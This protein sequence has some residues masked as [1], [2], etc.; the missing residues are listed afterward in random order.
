MC[1]MLGEPRTLASRN[2]IRYECSHFAR[3]H[4]GNRA[5]IAM[6]N[7]TGE[8]TE[9]LGMLELTASGRLLMTPPPEEL[10]LAIH[11][12]DGDGA[13]VVVPTESAP[14]PARDY[15]PEEISAVGWKC[16]MQASDT[17]RLRAVLQQL[18]D[19]CI[20]ALV[21]EFKERPVGVVVETKAKSCFIRVRDTLQASKHKAVHQSVDH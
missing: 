2:K 6:L 10:A 4:V 14:P 9:H 1:L 12:G 15:S 18:P 21:A 16:R 11:H 20:Q 7:T 19:T 5:F 17:R 8:M 13:A 3:T